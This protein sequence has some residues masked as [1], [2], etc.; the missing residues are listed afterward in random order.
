[1]R[2]TD[3]QLRKL[4]SKL[5]VRREC[6]NCGSTNKMSIVPDQYLLTSFEYSGGSYN[7]GG[8][9]SFMPLAAGVCPD[10]GHTM[11]YNLKIIG[12]VD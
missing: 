3:E 5:K 7:I 6:P 12:V 10:C 8:P 2:L 4:Q 9:M 1:M 11:L